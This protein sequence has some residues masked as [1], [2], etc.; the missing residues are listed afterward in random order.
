MTNA[1]WNIVS[2]H[3]KRPH[4]WYLF[5]LKNMQKTFWH[6][7]VSFNQTLFP[8]C[9][10][11]FCVKE[12]SNRRL[13]WFSVCKNQ[14]SE[15][16]FLSFLQNIKLYLVSKPQFQDQLFTTD[17]SFSNLSKIF[18]KFCIAYHEWLKRRMNFAVL[19]ARSSLTFTHRYMNKG[20]YSCSTE[21]PVSTL[22]LRASFRS[23]SALMPASSSSDC[24]PWTYPKEDY[25]LQK[26]E[27]KNLASLSLLKFP[28]KLTA[29]GFCLYYLRA[30]F[31]LH[32]ATSIIEDAQKLWT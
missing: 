11:Y 7:I 23:Y 32:K 30:C 21:I 19:T 28:S 9:M 15:I 24:Y 31:R 12:H 17:T 25:I 6:T 29:P 27:Q 26:Q 4:K 22:G 18:K 1:A 14:R 5:V 10:I 20:L 8:F 2:N 3:Q 16:T 13:Y